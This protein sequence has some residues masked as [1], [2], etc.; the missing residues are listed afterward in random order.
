MTVSL[1]G[2]E[3]FWTLLSPSASLP[4][5]AKPDCA[6]SKPP[7]ATALFFRN[8]R[9]DLRKDQLKTLKAIA[10]RELP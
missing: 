3:V 7:P 8:E 5:V 9:S 4:I 6:S 10:A 2:P 1:T